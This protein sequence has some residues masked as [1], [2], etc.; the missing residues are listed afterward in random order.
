MADMPEK[1]WR[2][3]RSIQDMLIE[4][5]S[6]RLNAEIA[7]ILSRRDLTARAK[8]VKVHEA[9]QRHYRIVAECF[10]HWKRSNI[11]LACRAMVKH[12]VFEEIDLAALTAE[13]A[14]HIQSM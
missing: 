10:D 12:G 9:A 3:L 13:T 4:R 2:F 1:D 11:W 8:R 7:A 5:L 14:E 6:E